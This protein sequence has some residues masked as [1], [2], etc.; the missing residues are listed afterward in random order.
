MNRSSM[1]QKILRFAKKIKSIN[2]L[3]STCKICR[4]NN[5]FK[6]TF[7][8]IDTSEKEFEY[9]DYKGYR[10]SVLKNEL[11]K[12]I[13]LCQNCHRE[14]HYNLDVLDDRRKDKLIYLDYSGSRCI[15]CG[16]NKC[17]ASLTFHHRNPEEKEF[18]IGGL[19]ERMSSIF[20]LKESIKSEIDK[21]DVLCANCHVLEHTDIDFFNKNKDIIENKVISYKEIQRKID[22]EE[23]YKMYDSGFKQ[24]DIAKHFSTSNGVISD[25]L[26]I[27]K[28][29]KNIKINKK[30][31]RDVVYNLIDRGY[32]NIDIAKELGI[33]RDTVYRIIKDRKL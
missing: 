16:Y 1:N 31:D 33:S 7:H 17:P 14:L 9:S 26:K 19:N 28:N 23:V 18:W 13:L 30:V 29:S 3:G 25:I 5:I 2:Y 12:C 27:Y 32:K 24:K 15:K 20:D 11:D 4:E 6:L 22:R 8:H 10:W 21:C